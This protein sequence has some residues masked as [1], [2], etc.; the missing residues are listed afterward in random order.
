MAPPA[1]PHGTTRPAAGPELELDPLALCQRP[2]VHEVHAPPRLPSPD[3]P[4][5]VRLQTSCSPEPL[6]PPSRMHTHRLPAARAGLAITTSL[7]PGCVV[8]NTSASRVT[9]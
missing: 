4:P 6:P 5:A 8:G 7:T 1:M 3:V 2:P 9:T